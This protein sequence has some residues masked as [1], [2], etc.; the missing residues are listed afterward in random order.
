VAELNVT[1]LSEAAIA[2]EL[3][4]LTGHYLLL[5]DSLKQRHELHG[6]RVG[7]GFPNSRNSLFRELHR[8]VEWIFS[9]DAVKLQAVLEAHL[10]D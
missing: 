6:Q 8:E 10:R 5:G 4:G 2:M 3:G 1:R 7:T 9:N